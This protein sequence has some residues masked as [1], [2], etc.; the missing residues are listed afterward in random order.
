[1]ST[2]KLLRSEYRLRLTG[3]FNE[4]HLAVLLLAA[5]DLSA[6]AEAQAPGSGEIWMR[7]WV[8]P[9]HFHL[10][11]LPQWVATRVA[12]RAMSVVFPRLIG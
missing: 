11:G 10:G 1:M 2:A 3:A 9:V 4:T 8:A 6:F 5:Q 7:H 12:A